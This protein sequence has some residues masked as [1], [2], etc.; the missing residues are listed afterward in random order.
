[1]PISSK[2]IEAGRAFV[3][4]GGDNTELRSA[5]LA[6]KAEMKKWAAEMDAIGNRLI[7]VGAAMVIPIA[8]ATARFKQFDDEMRYVGV[9]SRA[10]A[11]DLQMLTDKAMLLGRTMSFTATQVSSAMAELA[12]GGFNPKEIDEAITGIMDLARATRTDVPTAVKIAINALRVFRIETSKMSEVSDTLVTVANNSTTTLIELG[13]A[14]EYSGANAYLWGESI[15]STSK[16]L[17]V[18][19][20]MGLKGSMAGT[21]LNQVMNQ[22]SA[23]DNVAKLRSM[24]VAVE[25]IA[26]NGA[27]VPRALGDI[28]AD[29]GVAMAA[30]PKLQQ[31][32]LGKELFNLR[33]ARAGLRL[34]NAG[35]EIAAMNKAMD[36]SAGIARR[37]AKAMDAGLGGAVRK[38]LS[39]LETLAIAIGNSLAPMLIKLAR[40]FTEVERKL[41][42]WVKVHP[43]TIANILK[44]G[45]SLLVLGVSFKIL[46]A[47]ISAGA[48][49]MAANPIVIALTAIA[50]VTAV[51]ATAWAESM[52]TGKTYGEAILALT[53]RIIGL[54][55]AYSDLEAQQSKDK[56]RGGKVGKLIAPDSDA[57]KT[58]L[59]TELSSLQQQLVKARASTSVATANAARGFVPG[60][61]P[62]GAFG[63]GPSLRDTKDE[64]LT[65]RANE[66]ILINQINALRLKYAEMPKAKDADLVPKPVD[67]REAAWFNMD[68]M[69]KFQETNAKMYKA[70]AAARIKGGPGGKQQDLA[71][72]DLE[73][74]YDLYEIKDDKSKEAG[75]KRSGIIA[76]WAQKRANIEKEYR[77][78]REEEERKSFET[79]EALR[80]GL[81]EKGMVKDIALIH[82]KYNA[83]RREILANKNID[84]A[85][86]RRKLGLNEEQRQLEIAGARRQ[87]DEKDKDDKRSL[88]FEIAKTEIENNRMTSRRQKELA[89]NALERNKALQDNA[90]SV[91]AGGADQS[92][93]INRLFGLKDNAI[94][95]GGISSPASRGTFSATELGRL[96]GSNGDPNRKTA[97]NTE[98]MAK[99]LDGMARNGIKLKDFQMFWAQ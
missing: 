60:S 43:D 88:Q 62:M 52:I 85:E 4:I 84:D 38:L 59:Q 63:G 72:L 33:G 96:G 50:A 67:P 94:N 74:N 24:G 80:I 8:L 98:L 47:I 37:A 87:Q 61:Q 75:W 68:Q 58:D 9:T 81:T 35:A 44:L 28:L 30:L 10:T 46:S 89:I 40:Q 51:V 26:V 55:N 21:A 93:L 42:E 1:M 48:L 64:L 83:E 29:L 77:E 95:Q 79:I 18:L 66:K 34:T 91:A 86:R 15:Q 36:E 14:L 27:R 56:A 32:Q 25:T 78:K 23:K 97:R 17:G 49:Q 53:N 2:A 90:K 70:I 6:A 41:S 57:T 76:E 22:I 7:G 12:K 20:I 54:R 82:N 19:A 92:A 31:L 16:A 45:A 11:K 73:K 39:A 3:R 65:A 69:Q 71:M 5:L 13:E 99:Q